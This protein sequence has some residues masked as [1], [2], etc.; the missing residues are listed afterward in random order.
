MIS[1]ARILL[2][3]ALYAVAALL[4]GCAAFPGVLVCVRLWTHTAGWAPSLR[5]LTISC[6][7]AAM[8]FLFGFLLILLAGVCRVLFRLR[9]DEGEYPLASAGAVRWFIA[10]GLQTL[11]T[12]LFMDFILLTPFASFF[13]RILGAT[14][15]HQVQ[16]NSKYCADASLLEIGDGTIIGGH[17]TVIGHSFERGRLI[18]KRVRIGRRALIGLNAVVLPG[19]E[20]GDGA[21]IAAGAMVPKDTR[22][23]PH[24]VYFGA[25]T[26]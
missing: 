12:V 16:I 25:S 19:A 11:V 23:A 13:Y 18:L 3:L 15:G 4:L 24:T 21:T 17:A 9:L 14:V 10:N 26:K 6:C 7:A 20:I 8:Y 1:L 5:L 2:M 22:I